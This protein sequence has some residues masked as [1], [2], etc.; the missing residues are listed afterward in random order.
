[1]G[2]ILQNL[3]VESE[4]IKSII[5]RIEEDDKSSIAAFNSWKDHD[6]YIDPR[7]FARHFRSPPDNISI[8]R[9]L[10]ES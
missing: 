10:M 3:R 7:H 8:K 1:M 9:E 2:N 5:H 6:P 4:Y